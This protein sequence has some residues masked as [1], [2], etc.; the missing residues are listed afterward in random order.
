[1]D[2]SGAL[3]SGKSFLYSCGTSLYSAAETAGAA[4]K[5][6]AE[7]AVQKGKMGYNKMVNVIR[8]NPKTA[9]ITGLAIAA[10]LVGVTIAARS[11]NGESPVD[12]DPMAAGLG[13]AQTKV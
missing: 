1:M 10:T 5:D 9:V 13:G 2:I 4:V 6:G 8:E 12:G 7:A 11:Y 3:Q